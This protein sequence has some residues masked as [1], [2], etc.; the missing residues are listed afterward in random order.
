MA[1]AGVLPGRPGSRGI[2][3]RRMPARTLSAE[4]DRLYQLPLD[5]F[6]AA[7]NALA[8]D[9]GKDAGDIRKLA[10]PPAAA[11]AINQV[12]WR[13]RPLF[14]A[15]TAAASAVRAAHTAIA[16]GKRADLRAAGAAHEETLDAVLK[17]ALAILAE[18]GQPATDATKQAIATTLRAL[19]AV[20]EVPGRLTRTLQ[21]RGFELLA[22]LPSPPP[23]AS[24]ER[25]RP[26]NTD[27]KLEDVE[28]KT[29]DAD[30]A[31]AMTAAK[32]A[33][34]SAARVERAAEQSARRDEFEAGRSAREAE[35]A[36]TRLA[37][38]REKLATAQEAADEAEAEAAAGTRKA[39]ADARRV[40]ESADQLARARV[41]TEAA[42]AA[43]NRLNG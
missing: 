39:D 38:A 18:T 20:D 34:A 41:K 17:G 14:D 37:E 3:L 10:K 23:S 33:V 4:I 13:R 35:R 28:R 16:A 27:R 11:W 26:G 9:A 30:R 40:R 12:F 19:P 2:I 6:T 21:P 5:E 25:L 31:K 15:F 42:E 32:E 22:G 8:K 7:R 24:R 43:L 1:A 29:K 36:K